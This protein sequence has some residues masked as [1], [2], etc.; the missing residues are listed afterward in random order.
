MFVDMLYM[1]I[2]DYTP[3]YTYTH[4][5]THTYTHIHTTHM[6]THAHITHTHTHTCTHTPQL[7]CIS[8]PLKSDHTLRSQGGGEGVQRTHTGL[9]LRARP[10]AAGE[11]HLECILVFKKSCY[12]ITA[13]FSFKVSQYHVLL[14]F[15]VSK[16]YD[17]PADM[18][19]NVFK[20][21]KKG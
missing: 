11:L 18:I 3:P 10:Q 6:H 15:Q 21:T 9:P 1:Y 16:K 12:E 5:H 8:T 19:K 20:K 4:T 17:V 13:T 2:V 14:I 7:T